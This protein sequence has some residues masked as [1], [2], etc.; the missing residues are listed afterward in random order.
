MIGSKDALVLEFPDLEERFGEQIVN[1][2]AHVL[3]RDYLRGSN[4]PVQDDTIHSRIRG[5]DTAEEIAVYQAV[6]RRLR[7]RDPIL[8]AIRERAQYLQE[9]GHR[10]D[11]LETALLDPDRELPDRFRLRIPRWVCTYDLREQPEIDRDG[12]TRRSWGSSRPS[13]T[14]SS[15]SSR[16]TQVTLAADGGREP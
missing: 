10:P 7:N 3:N 4:G 14:S 13:R 2:A 8:E 1:T 12:R 9:N 16:T 15:S 6:E 5:L 11:D